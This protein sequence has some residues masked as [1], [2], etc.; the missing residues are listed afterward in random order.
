VS[1][2]GLPSAA[3]TAIAGGCLHV[4]RPGAQTNTLWLAGIDPATGW[5]LWAR[6]SEPGPSKT[7]LPAPVVAGDAV[8]ALA[9]S[10]TQILVYLPD[11]RGGLLD[12]EPLRVEGAEFQTNAFGSLYDSDTR[13]VVAGDAVHIARKRDRRAN[14]GTI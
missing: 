12:D 4:V 14:V 10:D 3:P 2:P 1:Q 5:H 7:R 8:L 13:I 6:E 11:L 9:T